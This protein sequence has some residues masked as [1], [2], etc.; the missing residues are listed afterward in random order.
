MHYIGNFHADHS[1]HS[2]ITGPSAAQTALTQPSCCVNITSCT[3]RTGQVL[4]NIDRQFHPVK[5]GNSDRLEESE[6]KIMRMSEVRNDHSEAGAS[7][8]KTDSWSM[9][10]GYPL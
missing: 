10:E 1:V 8:R 6:E 4:L 2:K 9:V 3:C 7:L 5:T